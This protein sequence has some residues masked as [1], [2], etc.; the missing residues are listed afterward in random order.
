MAGFVGDVAVGEELRLVHPRIELGLH[1]I[2]GEVLC[3][4]HEVVDGPLWP[5]AVVHLEGVALL[6]EV[7]LRAAQ[8][9]GSGPGEDAHRREVAVDGVAGEREVAVDGSP[10]KLCGVK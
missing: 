5:V 1:P 2:V 4:R 10:V 6:E 7:L 8:R 3:P 9:L